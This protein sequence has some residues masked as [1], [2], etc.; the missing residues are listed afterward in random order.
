MAK[1]SS[2]RHD[3][4][5]SQYVPANYIPPMASSDSFPYPFPCNEILFD[6]GRYVRILRPACTLTSHKC[7]GIE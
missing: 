5:V 1:R 3:S 6:P 2:P 4:E 7:L